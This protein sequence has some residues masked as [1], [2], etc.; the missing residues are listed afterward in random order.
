M[1]ALRP[2]NR[3]R[4]LQL[5]AV[6]AAATPLAGCG[7]E[8]LL[9]VGTNTWPG[10]E[11]LHAANRAGL[12]PPARVRAMRL[13]SATVVQQALAT[14]NIDA[15]GL[16]LDEVLV[17]RAAGIRIRI[18]A[19]LDVSLGGDVVLARPG[20][21]NAAQIRGQR[22]CS[23][24]SAVG[25]VMLAAFLAHVGLAATDVDL[26]YAP[27]DRHLAEY[28]NGNASIVVTFNPVAQA[29][30]ADGATRL[31]DSAEMDG[32]IMDVLVATDAAISEKPD[33]LKRLVAAHFLALDSFQRHPDDLRVALAAGLGVAPAELEA[34]YKGLAMQSPVANYQ[35]LE[36]EPPRLAR[37]ALTVGG[38][39]VKAGLLA[40]VP[41]L[42]GLV[43]TRF[44]PPK[45]TA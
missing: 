13:P 32:R 3:R 44:L 12:L 37:A 41:D 9:Q 26:I 29:L 30:L 40:A 27:V 4:F 38:V 18:I 23:E 42:A 36:D 35:W 34:S 5:L 25:A 1:H 39:M 14:G 28:R 19:L 22:V 16:T 15:A 33:G 8:V 24:H 11:F 10:Y 21:Q 6:G 17:A 20:I 7:R 2:V 43:E 31:F 45:I